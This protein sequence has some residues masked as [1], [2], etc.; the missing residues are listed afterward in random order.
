M[1]ASRL[2]PGLLCAAL[3]AASA[4]S[5]QAPAMPEERPT[6]VAPT[7]DPAA[8]R[9]L[10]APEGGRARVRSS[11]T[12]DVIAP[13]EKVDTIIGKMRVER[14]GPAPERGGSSPPPPQLRGPDK[15]RGP[16]GDRP[17]PGPG[18]GP[19]GR[20]GPRGGGGPP[21]PPR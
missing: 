12:V 16:E 7:V 10:P 19:G 3:L 14:P 11:H 18:G 8:A 1:S 20:P 4:A 17:G 2:Q 13:G 15:R 9:P 21:P 5:A 6:V